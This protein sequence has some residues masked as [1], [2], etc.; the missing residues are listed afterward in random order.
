M[1]FVLECCRDSGIYDEI[2]DGIGG[3]TS[4]NGVA[5]RHTGLVRKPTAV[6]NPYVAIR[7]SQIVSIRIKPKQPQ[8]AIAGHKTDDATVKD[9]AAKDD[10]SPAPDQ[11]WTSSNDA[12]QRDSLNVSMTDN[13]VYEKDSITDQTSADDDAL[14]QE[15]AAQRR[16][17]DDVTMTDNDVYESEVKAEETTGDSADMPPDGQL[18]DQVDEN[19]VIDDSDESEPVCRWEAVGEGSACDWAIAIYEKL[20][21]DLKARKMRCWY[22]KYEYLLECTQ[23]K[24]ERGCCKKRKLMLAMTS[25]ILHWL[26]R[27]QS[28]LNEVEFCS[29][30]AEADVL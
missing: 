24:G 30:D 25:R 6:E 4:P 18:M 19:D 21:M 29:V 14:E 23:C 22:D 17:E 13:D 20:E 16:A 9:D 15:T 3:A 27:S 7:D 8:N 10:Q 11:G 1:R 5:L 12:E 28:Q 26:R 2:P